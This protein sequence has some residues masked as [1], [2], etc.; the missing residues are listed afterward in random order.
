MS[1]ALARLALAAAAFLLAL[2]P[3]AAS[4]QGTFPAFTMTS[5]AS[6][7]CLTLKAPDQSDGGG[8]TTA[9]CQ[10]FSNFFVTVAGGTGQAQLQ[11]RLNST[12]FVCVFATNNPVVSPSGQRAKVET[13]NCAPP[14]SPVPKPSM[15]NVRGPDN[16]GF[17]QIEKLSNDIDS[18][19]FCIFENTQASPTP[20]IDLEVC[21]GVNTENWKL[22]RVQ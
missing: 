22:N 19:N 1:K 18:S 20:E 7:N 2:N 14:G 3:F 4:A 21:Q 11:F 8:L 5:Q 13:R 6:G 12:R 17:Q 9:P 16:A 15:W 10:N